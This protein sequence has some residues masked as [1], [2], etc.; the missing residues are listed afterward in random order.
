MNV[1]KK[2]AALA[3]VAALS[4]PAFAADLDLATYADATGTAD[5]LVPTMQAE[6]VA[7]NAVSADGNFALIYQEV[8]SANAYIEQS[9]ANNFAAIIQSTTDAPSA[10]VM[11]KGDANR[12]MIYQH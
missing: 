11:Q 8:A 1:I 6:M 4:A 9:G 12:A 3:A 7:A 10:F 5:G 2:L